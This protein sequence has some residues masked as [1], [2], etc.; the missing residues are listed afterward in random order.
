MPI[1]REHPGCCSVR[2]GKSEACEMRGICQSPASNQGVARFG[3]ANPKHVRCGG[4]ANPPRAIRCCSVRIGKSEP[5]EVRGICQ[6]PA[7]NQGV[8][9][10]GLTN[11]KH[12]RCGGFDNPPRATRVLL[13]S[14]WQIRS[15]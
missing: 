14:E 3:L 15:M 1:P 2:I 12:V 6:S 9:R 13:G 5:C 10:F 4:F 7:S 11:P 8:A